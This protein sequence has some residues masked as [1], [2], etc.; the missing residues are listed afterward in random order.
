M[1][2]EAI[3]SESIRAEL[4]TKNCLIIHRHISLDIYKIHEL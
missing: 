2:D 1:G 3:R 4:R